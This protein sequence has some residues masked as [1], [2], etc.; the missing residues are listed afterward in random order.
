[1]SNTYDLNWA[2][3]LRGRGGYAYDN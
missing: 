3:H 2:S 1:L